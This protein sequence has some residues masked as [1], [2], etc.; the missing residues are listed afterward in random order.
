MDVRQKRIRGAAGQWRLLLAFHAGRAGHPATAQKLLAPI[1][2]G[3]TSDQQDTAQA[4][5]RALGGPR[6]GVR[7][8]I[9][10]L[11]AQLEAISP[12]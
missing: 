5:L 7:L 2:N 12:A 11:E 6:A 3:G 10:I 9:I 4:V 8:L 1:I